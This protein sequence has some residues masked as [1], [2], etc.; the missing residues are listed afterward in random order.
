M[1]KIIGILQ[2]AFALSAM[3]SVPYAVN[4]SASPSQI[5]TADAWVS[6]ITFGAKGDG[7]TDDTTAIQ[8]TINYVFYTNGSPSIIYFPSVQSGNGV[9]N[10]APQT[11]YQCLSS[12]IIPV[13]PTKVTEDSGKPFMMMGDGM[14]NSVLRFPNDSATNFIQFLVGTANT[15]NYTFLSNF[16]FKNLGVWGPGSTNSANEFTGTDNDNTNILANG[17][18]LGFSS[19]V[20]YFNTSGWN[21]IIENCSFFGWKDAVIC[22]NLV[23]FTVSD[24]TFKWNWHSC[25]WLAGVDTFKIDHNIML[26]KTPTNGVGAI[27]SILQNSSGGGNGGR[28]GNICW[29]EI[30][31]YPAAIMNQGGSLS[32]FGGNFE[33]NGAVCIS[34]NGGTVVMVRPNVLAN[35]IQ[36]PGAWVWGDHQGSAAS[37]IIMPTISVI[38]NGLAA[39]SQNTNFLVMWDTIASYQPPY[40]SFQ[41]PF[42]TTPSSAEIYGQFNGTRTVFFNTPNPSCQ[43]YWAN[44]FIFVGSGFG[45]NDSG[46][47]KLGGNNNYSASLSAN[48]SKSFFIA[49]PSF[50]GTT[51]DTALLYGN[52]N[53]AGVNIL[54]IGWADRNPSLQFD[55]IR[56]GYNNGI[57]M[58]YHAGNLTM[59]SVSGSGGALTV[60]NGISVLGGGP[61]L[62][63]TNILGAGGDNG[64]ITTN[65]GI[66]QSNALNGFVFLFDGTALSITNKTA[67]GTGSSIGTTGVTNVG[68]VIQET[69]N[70]SAG[71]YSELSGSNVI[72]GGSISTLANN[73]NLNLWQSNPA[74]VSPWFFT[75]TTPYDVQVWAYMGTNTGIGIGGPGWGTLIGA[76]T[77][78]V[79][80]GFILQTGEVIAFTNT[81]APS[82]VVIKP[83]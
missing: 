78:T 83:L 24:S 54:G 63:W 6:V 57:G 33:R 71:N 3:G 76:A 66:L 49:V 34:S 37:A 52:M 13:S 59:N 75:N 16:R 7:V 81:T 74:A 21:D 14:Y 70:S 30:G 55:Y 46:L 23:A 38:T 8:N 79:V 44:D 53:S 10:A 50:A 67:A 20:L 2:A 73:K 1:K 36:Q 43:S 58:E 26:A 65:A 25:V 15:N 9:G 41:A 5:V 32:C 40:V 22:T 27:V 61:A 18:S 42:P 11:I 69:N 45:T 17:I 28:G 51:Y 12:L 62:S 39:N 72:A 31:G 60:A 35:T 47:F 29:N 4:P 64:V 48:T 80:G 82:R 19:N 68:G 77:N 56:F